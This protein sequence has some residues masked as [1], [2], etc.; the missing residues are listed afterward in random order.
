MQ[1]VLEIATDVNKKVTVLPTLQEDIAELKDDVKVIKLAVT[2]TNKDL[3]LL[4][5]RV[6][7]LEQKI[8]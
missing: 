6:T 2:D 3:K 8:A 4:E 1:A 7:V 5:R